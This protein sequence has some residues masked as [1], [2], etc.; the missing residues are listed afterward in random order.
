[1]FLRGT[2]EHNTFRFY[3]EQTKERVLAYAVVLSGMESGKVKG[4]I[5]ELDYAAKAELA[6]QT[7]LRTDNNRLIYEKGS[8][9]LPK[10]YRFEATPD[11]EYGKF[12]CY[13]AVPHDPDALRDLLR[14]ESR[15]RERLKPGNFKEH[16]GR[17]SDEKVLAEA[18][19]LSAAF[20]SLQAPNSP[21]G[22]HFVVE[23]SPW[24]ERIASS[25]E[26]ERLFALLPYKTLYLSSVKDRHGVFA[27]ISKDERRDLPLRKQRPSV[28]A[29]LKEGQSKKAAAPKKAAAKA[30]DNDLE[31]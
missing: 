15:K 16:I 22:T 14:D 31:V 23:V 10:E 26:H 7:A 8:R 13:E 1:M 30:K 4:S 5:Y 18:Q 11:R 24:F 27:F 25:K 29:Q 6:I 9:E 20:Q 12:V 19:R 2:R 17:L 3:H 21:N 28:R